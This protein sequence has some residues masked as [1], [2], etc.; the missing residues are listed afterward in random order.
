MVLVCS[1]LMISGDEHLFM[2]LLAISMSSGENVYSVPLPLFKL[3]GFP[4]PTPVELHEFI[5]YCGY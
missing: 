3:G 2:Y 5:I 4:T 1:A